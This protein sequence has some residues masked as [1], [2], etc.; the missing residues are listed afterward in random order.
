MIENKRRR[1]QQ[2][3]EGVDR[4]KRE[5]DRAIAADARIERKADQTARQQAAIDGN[6][7]HERCLPREHAAQ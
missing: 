4:I 3:A 5:D 2:Q 6:H 1:R 7:D